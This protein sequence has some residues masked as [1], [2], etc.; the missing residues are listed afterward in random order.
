MVSNEKAEWTGDEGNQPQLENKTTLAEVKHVEQRTPSEENL[1]Y[2]EV[3]E[4]PELHARTYVALA[5]MFL[6]NLVQVVALQGPPAVVGANQQLV[7][8]DWTDCIA[9]LHRNGPQES[10]SPDMGSKCPVS[11]ASCHFAHYLLRLRHLSSSQAAARG[12]FR[13]LVCWSSHCTWVSQHLQAHHRPDP[14]WIWLCIGATRV[15]RAK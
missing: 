6:L 11:G 15:L 3:D 7:V 13:H 5:A 1:V 2:D 14:D 9:L 10:S 4:E 8:V 12:L